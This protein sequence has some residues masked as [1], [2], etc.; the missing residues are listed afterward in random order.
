MIIR[1]SSEQRSDRARLAMD[2]FSRALEVV[3]ATLIE[4]AGAD[5]LDT[6]LSLRA[7]T[8]GKDPWGINESGKV[9]IIT[10]SIIHPTQTIL[11]GII[12]ATEAVCSL[13]RIDQVI[14]ARGD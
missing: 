6:I 10:P 8:N 2:A 5:V 3:P 4:N 14:S 9:E 12:G 7:S 11:N 1:K 13:L